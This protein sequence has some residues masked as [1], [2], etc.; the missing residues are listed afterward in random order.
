MQEHKALHAPPKLFT[1]RR[2]CTIQAAG[3]PS[4]T[5]LRKIDA[6]WHAIRHPHYQLKGCPPTPPSRHQAHLSQGS[7]HP[8]APLQGMQHPFQMSSKY[9]PSLRKGSNQSMG[10]LT[11]T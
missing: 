11:G 5:S 3:N 7:K 9:P 6:Y 8:P 4:S 10:L 1:P 2:Q